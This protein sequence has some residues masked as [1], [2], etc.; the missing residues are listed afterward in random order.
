MYIITI[1]DTSGGPALVL[2]KTNLSTFSRLVTVLNLN[3]SAS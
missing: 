1:P 2:W 3:K